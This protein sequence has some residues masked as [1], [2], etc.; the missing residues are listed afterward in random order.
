MFDRCPGAEGL[1]RPTILLRTCPQCG[2]EIEIFSDEAS[3]A[4][5]DCGF[6]IYNDTLSC[7]TWCR[8]ARECLGDEV[9]ERYLADAKQK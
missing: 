9:Y 2:A 5:S 3:A 1:R 4:C 7:I 6:V 8:Y